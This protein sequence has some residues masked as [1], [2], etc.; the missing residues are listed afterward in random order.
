MD[1]KVE[2]LKIVMDLIK[3]DEMDMRYHRKEQIDLILRTYALF[4][5][6]LYGTDKNTLRS[7]IRH[8]ETA[9]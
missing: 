6:Q 2:L 7:I 4:S 9:E 8:L 5:D 3:I 1:S